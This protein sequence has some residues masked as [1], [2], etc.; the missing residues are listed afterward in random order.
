[1][2][3]IVF[4][5]R[6]YKKSITLFQ[7]I[8]YLR[9]HMFT[10][11]ILLTLSLVLTAC[12]SVTSSNNPTVEGYNLR[13]P[14]KTLI[15]PEILKEVSGVTY[16]D[17]STIACI[18]D[19][20]GI[21]F[22]YDI[23][24]GRIK[25]QYNFN[26]D[27]DYEGITLV[28]RTMYIL[29]SDGVLFEIAD[30]KA[31]DFSLK[32]YVTG[33]P[34]NNNEGL[35]YD[36]D[37]KR[38]LIASKSKIGKGPEFKDKRFIYAFDLNKKKLAQEP[39]FSFDVQVIKEFAQEKKLNLPE[40]SRKSGTVPVLKFFPSAICIHPVTKNLFLLSAAD[41]MLFI[42]K[43]DGTLEHIEVLDHKIFNKSEGI[44]FFSNGDM[45]ITNEGQNE[46]PTLL[47]FNYLN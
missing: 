11:N 20:N 31:K 15:L 12:T 37:N 24:N 5:F 10:A 13:S 40:K 14:D 39:V 42:F 4:Y 8:R 26:I 3:G 16:I 9:F 23:A 41:H 22:I 27:G 18:Q 43:P 2:N 28:D 34:A 19:E 7:T 46:K 25:G 45:L 47:R 33:I 44:T 30:Y 38:L 6:R 36:K 29:R 17:E 35:C 1:M 32:T 21:L